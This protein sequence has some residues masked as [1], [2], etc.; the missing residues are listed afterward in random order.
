VWPDQID[1]L[2]MVDATEVIMQQLKKSSRLL[3]LLLT[4]LDIT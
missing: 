2:R 3:I 4:S 1:T